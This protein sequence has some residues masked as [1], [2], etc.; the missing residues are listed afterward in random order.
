MKARTGRRPPPSAAAAITLQPAAAIDL[1]TDPSGH[2]IILLKD[3]KG[4]G[5]AFARVDNRQATEIVRQL[6]QYILRN[7]D[8]EGSPN[9][10]TQ[11]HADRSPD[12]GDGG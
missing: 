3:A 2:I 6:R 1:G 8:P 7:I 5:L 12:R 4:A 11:Q 9:V 10:P